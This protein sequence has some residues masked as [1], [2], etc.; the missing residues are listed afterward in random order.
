MKLLRVS[1]AG[2]MGIVLLA[3]VGFAAL[4][5][6]TIVWASVLFTLT[7]MIFCSAILG[8]IA[9]RG[10]AR[11]TWA[12]FAVFGWVYLGIAFGIGSES[13]GATSPPFVTQA[14]YDSMRDWPS[15]TWMVQTDSRPFGER[16][17]D[18][19]TLTGNLTGNGRNPIAVTQVKPVTVTRI[20]WINLR[21]VVHTLG[22]MAFALIGAIV[23]RSFAVRSKTR[24]PSERPLLAESPP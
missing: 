9:V 21:R 16:F 18:R 19:L 22:A 17:L 7:V 1:I 23:G 10:P 2:S 6:P 20:D 8:A 3:A 12:G 24:P 14:L 15:T 11:L 13:N 4:R 5:N